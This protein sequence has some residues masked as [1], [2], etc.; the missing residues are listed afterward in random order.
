M[1]GSAGAIVNGT[2]SMERYP[3]MASI[4]ESAP[5]QGLY[6]GACGASP[7]DP[8]WALTA[9]HRVRGDGLVLDGIVRIGSEERKSGGTVRAIERTEV[10]PGSTSGDGKGERHRAGPPRP[11]GHREAHPDR[12]AG[13]ASTPMCPPTRTGSGRPSGATPE[14]DSRRPETPTDLCGGYAAAQLRRTL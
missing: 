8:Q 12:G 14:P 9:A 1:T 3:F 2:D 6:D 7:I 13:R 10:H 4:P 5:K 11:P